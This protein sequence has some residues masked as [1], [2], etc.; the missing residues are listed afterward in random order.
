MGHL[1]YIHSFL[2]LKI[3]SDDLPVRNCCILGTDIKEKAG[4][5]PSGACSLMKE[6]DC[7]SAES[8][9]CPAGCMESCM[10][11]GNKL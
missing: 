8:A 9:L 10:E 7:I 4:H 1:F 5:L 2:V 3:T 6:G 11:K